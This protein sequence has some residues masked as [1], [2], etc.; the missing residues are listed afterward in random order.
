MLWLSGHG[1]WFYNLYLMLNMSSGSFNSEEHSCI[2]ASYFKHTT[3]WSH[4][5][6]T[7]PLQ[8]QYFYSLM[9]LLYNNFVEV[10]AS[11]KM[12]TSVCFSKHKK[13]WLEHSKADYRVWTLS[14]SPNNINCYKFLWTFCLQIRLMSIYLKPRKRNENKR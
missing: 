1:Y 5:P 6:C 12:P 9:V 10:P 14:C 3:H 2:V 7:H 13:N 8:C 11:I 4:L